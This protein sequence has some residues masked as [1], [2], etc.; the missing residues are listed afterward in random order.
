M[1]ISPVDEMPGADPSV[2]HAVYDA[3]GGPKK[4]V[5]IDGGHFGLLHHPSAWFDVASAAQRDFLVRALQ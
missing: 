1:Q 5:E 4:I 2:A 3:V